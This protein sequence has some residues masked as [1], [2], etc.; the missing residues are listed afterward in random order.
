MKALATAEDGFYPLGASGYWHGGIHFGQKTGGFLKQSEGVCAI[1]AGEVVAY[2][3]DSTYPELTY[4][5][6]KQEKRHAL[7]STGFVL[8]RH[9]LTLPPAPK[10]PDS[11]PAPAPSKAAPTSAPTGAS[12][13]GAKSP[14]QAPAP[15]SPPPDET[16]TFFSLYMHTLDWATYQ[17]ALKQAGTAGAS[18]KAQHIKIPSY[19]ETERIYR[20]LK[21]NK[22]EVPKPRPVTSD[23]IEDLINN[24]FDISKLSREQ[25]DEDEVQPEPVSG[26]RVR[27]MPN[28][29]S[30][31]Y[32]LLPEGTE[33]ILKESDIGNQS[34]WAKIVEIRPGDA[35]VAPVVGQAVDPNVR[36][37]Y[38]FVS[39]LELVPQSGPLDKVV[40]LSTPHSVKAGEV[41]AHI[42]Q[43]QR[44]REAKSIKP[45]PTRPLLHLEVFAGPDLPEFIK[46][47]QDRA[48]QL[49]DLDKPFLEIPAGTKL[50]TKIPPPNFTL[51]KPGLK[52]VPVSDSKSRWVR[53]QPK[54]VTMPPAQPTLAPASKGKSKHPP[55]KKHGPVE[56]PIGD[57]FWVD[58]SQVNKMTTGSVQGWTDFPL[59]ISQADGPGTDFRDVFRVVDL[60]KYDIQNIAREGKDA[61][62]KSKRWWNVVVGTKDGG[63]RQG[64][65]RE[66]DHFKARLC[67]P[68]DWPGFELVDNS[69]VTPSEM[70]KRY[71]FVAG[72]AIGADQES[73]KTSADTLANSELIQRLETAIDANHDGRVTA[74][75]LATAQNVP[76][77]AEAISHMVVKSESE[78]GGNMGQWEAIT[79]YMKTMS[80]KWQNEMERIRKLQWW[81]DVKSQNKTLLPAEPKP[82]HLHPIGLIGNF[83]AKGPS[84]GQS[85]SDDGMWFI[86]SHEA[87]A[88][89]TNRLHWPGG[90]SGVTLGA[91]YDM[92]GRSEAE[93]TA[94]MKAIGLPDETASGIAKAAG[95]EGADAN[96]FAR[97]NRNL[98]NL[99]HEQEVGLLRH[100]VKPYEAMV[101]NSIKVQL[102]QNQFD[103]LVSFAYNPAARWDSV[104][105]L[106]NNGKVEAAM[107]KIKEGVT[108]KG[109]VLP[110]LVNR[111]ADEVNLYQEGRYEMNGVPIRHE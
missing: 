89:T 13:S 26:V 56:T 67:S 31:I 101:R 46:K 57:P 3:L 7:Y 45:L 30:K 50:V 76:W 29:K 88:G 99:T 86:F 96:N 54:S 40:V 59:K 33:V 8:V 22:Q 80:W 24:N 15:S 78:W 84:I 60:D 77:S 109:Q 25:R 71:L 79:P 85:L 110:G 106:V 62:G 93:I 65:V 39:E 1:A 73:F 42:G 102:S 82:W 107:S 41:I 48:K 92:K 9:T 44:Y 98:V 4:D 104:T 100:T 74:A 32:G 90:A 103:A 27:A 16:L 75:E 66:E 53:V 91:G 58:S 21:P 70:F 51:D 81:E 83:T 49:P 47:S 19:W 17:A 12:R 61:T 11:D 20:A 38:V 108:S 6:P 69:S 18:S 14:A 55:A 2:R 43:Y 10:K 5:E 37:G 36:W 111:R 72:L 87:Q 68:W 28:S 94:D 35:A 97:N 52:L 64:W 34:G 95:K 63:T 105:N 23:A